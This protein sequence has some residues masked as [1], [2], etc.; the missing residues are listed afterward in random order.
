[1][2]TRVSWKNE[3]SHH[4]SVIDILYTSHQSIAFLWIKPL[5]CI[6]N[7]LTVDTPGVQSHFI[8]FCLVSAG[9][10]LW[11]C[12]PR[13][14][15]CRKLVA[16]LHILTGK[17]PPLSDQNQ[18]V[19]NILGLGASAFCLPLPARLSSRC[20]G[21]SPTETPASI[22]CIFSWEKV[23][24]GGVGKKKRKPQWPTANRV[25]QV[26]SEVEI[27][28]CGGRLE[29][30]ADQLFPLVVTV[31]NLPLPTPANSHERWQKN[32]K[33][34]PNICRMINLTASPAIRGSG[35]V[36]RCIIGI[37]SP[38]R[39]KRSVSAADIS[40]LVQHTR[41]PL[42]SP[43]DVGSLSFSERVLWLCG[44]FSS[45]S[46]LLRRSASF[47]WRH[48]CCPYLRL[49]GFDEPKPSICNVINLRPPPAYLIQLFSNGITE[50]L[51]LCDPVLAA[52]SVSNGDST[53]AKSHFL[54][55]IRCGERCLTCC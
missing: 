6:S 35:W 46:L 48:T 37:T 13:R 30:L 49:D 52:S 53:A 10:A 3:V 7:I 1:M 18:P 40:S 9:K 36:G 14:H 5:K 43:L 33:K 19:T 25:G 29:R 16:C 42:I 27:Q 41:H 51:L 21:T 34:S 22:L 15:R 28:M 11:F 26:Y 8:S 47:S 24:C 44:W 2:E 17:W 12:F 4:Y 32:H 45:S 55:F 23:G 20:Q 31:V 54:W 50:T 39:D 38:S